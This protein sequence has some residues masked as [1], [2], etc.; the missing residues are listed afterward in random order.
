MRCLVVIPAY[1]AAGH[2]P[3]LIARIRTSAPGIGILIVNDGSA[4]ETETV[5]RHAG[6]EVISHPVNRGKGA[7]LM[8]GF[9][10]A[11]ERGAEAVIHMDADLQHEPE[12]LPDFVEAFERGEGDVII[13]SRDLSARHMPFSR[14]LSNT[15]CSW[16]VSAL[17]R[18]SV[19][20]SQCGYR[21]IS[22]AVMETV[23]PR[24]GGYTF[25]PEYLVLAGKAGFRIGAVSIG[26][27]YQDEKSY[28][29]PW[30][31]TFEFIGAMLRLIV[32]SPRTITA[33]ATSEPTH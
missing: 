7:A 8:T 5:A 21:L 27:V 11:M 13:G 19:A 4:D 6:V 33:R 22:R 1:N 17:A 16:T 32:S 30:R 23:H 31:D 12:S 9:G 18:Q 20:D 3:E 10:A 26:T 24:S 25:E 14:R 29:H 15:L 28:I 2:L